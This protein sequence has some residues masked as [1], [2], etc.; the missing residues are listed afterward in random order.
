MRTMVLGDNFK[1]LG[2]HW[3]QVNLLSP[4][5]VINASKMCILREF[6]KLILA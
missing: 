3:F 1:A 4:E 2:L 5:F 6:Y